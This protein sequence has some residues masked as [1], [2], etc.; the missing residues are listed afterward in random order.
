M[1]KQHNS[2]VVPPIVLYYGTITTFLKSISMHGLKPMPLQ[3]HVNLSPDMETALSM[4][5]VGKRSTPV[6]LCI[7]A[8][9]MHKD[10]IKFYRLDNDVYLTDF[11]DSKYIIGAD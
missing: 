2:K 3:N 1:E 5:V 4:Q 11:V 9:N 10:G 7:Y 6:L 8:Y